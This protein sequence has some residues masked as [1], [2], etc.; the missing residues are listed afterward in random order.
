MLKWLLFVVLALIAIVV[1]IAVVGYLLPQ[2]HVATRVARYRQP[3]GAVFDA[4]SDVA[5]AASWRTDLKQVAMLPPQQG[6]VRFREVGSSG[7]IVFEIDE[8]SRPTKMVTRIADPDQPFGGTWTFELTADGAGT[9]L[10]ITERG[11][12]YNPI[13]RTL[14]RFV[15]GHTSTLDAYLKALGTKFGESVTPGDDA[16]AMQ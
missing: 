4:I 5:S 12:I 8:T 16:R 13:F 10:A 2:D 3:P 1:V 6:R 15:F 14:A 11:E 7:S 9:R